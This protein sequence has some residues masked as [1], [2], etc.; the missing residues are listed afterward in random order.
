MS[1]GGTGSK[2]IHSG[3]VEDTRLED[4]LKRSLGL[5]VTIKRDKAKKTRGKIIVDFYSSSDLEEIY[6]RH[7]FVR[8]SELTIIVPPW[9]S[10]Q[11][12]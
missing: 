12:N 11:L 5:K 6:K 10:A 1:H 3:L 7:N 8:S 2:S 9:D 4:E